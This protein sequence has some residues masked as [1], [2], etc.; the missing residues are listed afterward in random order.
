MHSAFHRLPPTIRVTKGIKSFK[1]I[2]GILTHD[3][4]RTKARLPRCDIAAS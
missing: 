2:V 4:V 3:V 1:S